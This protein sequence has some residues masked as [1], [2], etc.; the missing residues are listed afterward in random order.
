[1]PPFFRKFFF[2]LDRSP[3]GLRVQGSCATTTANGPSLFACRAAVF[4]CLAHFPLRIRSKPFLNSD[5]A[6]FFCWCGV[7]CVVCGA[8]GTC[9]VFEEA[10]AFDRDIGSWDVS[11]VTTM[12]QSE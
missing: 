8:C 11:K 7:F 6:S 5:R 2:L 12:D 1:M 3:E 10:Y 9:A 4:T